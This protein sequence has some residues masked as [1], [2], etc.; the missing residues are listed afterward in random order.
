M[1]R[2]VDVRSL[3]AI[4]TLSEELS[5][6]HAAERLGMSQ[7][8]L[9]RLVS[10]L[11]H[12]YRV[13]LFERNHANVTLTDAGRGF[14]EEAKLALLHDERALLTARKIAEGVEHILTIGRTPYIDPFL[15]T[16]LLA[17]RLAVAVFGLNSGEAFVGVVGP[18][19]EVPALIGLVNVA[20]W[21]RRKYFTAETSNGFQVHPVEDAR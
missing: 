10:S 14:V 3:E 18:L 16:A 4:V 20:F 9:S 5:F 13:K 8:G 11:E 7:S 19:I 21:M 6:T 2:F 17:V 1:Q 15:T 12:R